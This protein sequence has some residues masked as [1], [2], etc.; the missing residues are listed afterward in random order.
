MQSDNLSIESEFKV[1]TRASFT[2]VSKVI[3]LIYLGFAML[4]YG[5]GLI[6]LCQFVR[7][8]RKTRTSCVSLGHVFLHFALSR[9]FALSFD[10]FSGLPV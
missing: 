4:N 8:T 9:V 10:W 1:G 7:S 6:N 3:H 2:Q 5:N